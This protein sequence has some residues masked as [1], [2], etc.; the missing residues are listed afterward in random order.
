MQ[1]MLMTQLLKDTEETAD[2]EPE[3][4]AKNINLSHLKLS[5][6]NTFPEILWRK[7]SRIQNI[8]DSLL[9]N[10]EKGSGNSRIP[11]IKSQQ[12]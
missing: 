12:R 10:P 9:K 5:L 1:I 8:W 4:G 6:H 7:K 2:G 11:E 3:E